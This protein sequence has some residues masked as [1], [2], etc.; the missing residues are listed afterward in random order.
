MSE[1]LDGSLVTL[2]VAVT[3]VLGTVLSGALGLYS[4]RKLKKLELEFTERHWRTSVEDEKKRQRHE[5]VRDSYIRLNREL[6]V[7]QELLQRKVKNISENQ[8]FSVSMEEVQDSRGSARDAY[9]EAQLYASEIVLQAARE[10]VNNLYVI[11]KLILQREA[12]GRH[13]C[14]MEEITT[15]TE[16]SRHQALKLRNA[17]RDE[18][19][20]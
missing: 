4:S 15:R 11:H 19:I 6:R 14:N 10:F 16:Q 3:G 20:T 12:S 8:G 17:M 9:S 2:I 5:E 18:I 13:E 1:K 7:F